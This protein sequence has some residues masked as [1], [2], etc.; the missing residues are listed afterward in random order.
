MAGRA[1]RRQKRLMT[2]NP[3]LQLLQHL[4]PIPLIRLIQSFPR[5]SCKARTKTRPDT[6]DM[7]THGISAVVVLVDQEQEGAMIQT[8]V[9]RH[10]VT[11]PAPMIRVLMTPAAAI[12][13]HHLTTGNT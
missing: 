1:P 8:I 10:R 4:L 7:M 13:L 3:T 9:V 12:V 11:I 5:Q 2:T 6:T